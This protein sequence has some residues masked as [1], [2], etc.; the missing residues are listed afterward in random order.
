MKPLEATIKE[1]NIQID[2]QAPLNGGSPILQYKIEVLAD[3][4]KNFFQ[5]QNCGKNAS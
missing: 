4:M 2:W 5:I 1:C 3:G